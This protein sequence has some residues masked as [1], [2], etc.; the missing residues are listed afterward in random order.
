[1]TRSSVARQVAVWVLVGAILAAGFAGAVL[2]EPLAL[3]AGLARDGAPTS[4]PPSLFA[5]SPTPAPPLGDDGLAALAP[6]P[7]P[8][9]LPVRDTLD[10][11]I[12]GL[13]TSLLEGVDGA[14]VRF[15]WEAVDVD[16]GEVV[17]AGDGGTPLIPASNTKTLTA[18]AAM[19][20]FS[21]QERF[22]TTIVQPDDGSIVLVGGGDPMLVSEPADP[23]FYP[24]PTS[25]RELAAATADALLEA[26]VTSVELGYDAS[27]FADDGW[28]DSWPDRYRDQVTQLSALW[29]DEGRTGGGRSRTPAL[30]AATIFAGQLADEGV[31][32]T[33]D[34]AEVR[35]SGPEIARVESL[36][37]HVLVETA[38][39]RS[40]NSFTETIGFQTALATGHPAT[41]E[42]SVAAIEEQLTGLGL[43][44]ADTS[45]TDASGLSRDN[46]ITAATLAGVARAMQT[47]PRLSVILD[48]LPTAGV[49]GTLALRFNDDVSS[50][51]R[52]VA[53][54]K[55]G[56]LSFVAT[57]SGTTR[58]DDGRQIAFA[59]MVNGAVN[60]WAAKVWTDQVAGVISDCGC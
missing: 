59:A 24:V 42:G 14:P 41:F 46:R 7:A 11:R 37:V 20:V 33:G 45:I 54:A 53:Q 10:A 52:G 30:D 31:T 5:A 22:A 2:R 8:G 35:A 1:M 39:T 23:E 26:G 48:G 49:T 16:T 43:W 18:V 6:A 29:V 15:A 9:A 19:N 34:P 60:G 57:L 51:A 28:N 32:V 21:G 58:T 40:N 3:A 50:P 36:P 12:A 55:T 17:A 44:G 4:A 13:D 47:D 25:T 27:L 56:T 38:L